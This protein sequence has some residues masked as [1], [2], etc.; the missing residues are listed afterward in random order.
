[1]PVRMWLLMKMQTCKNAKAQYNDI[2]IKYYAYAVAY[3]TMHYIKKINIVC[4]YVPM[5]RG[6]Q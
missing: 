4:I 5:W 3:R 2:Q 1:M 6:P